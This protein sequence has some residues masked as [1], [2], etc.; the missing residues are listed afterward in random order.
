[1]KTPWTKTGRT[2]VYTDG[3]NTEDG[4]GCAAVA[5]D[6]SVSYILNITASIF[7]AEI[8]AILMAVYQTRRSAAQTVTIATDSRIFIEA[9]RKLYP[10]TL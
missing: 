4:V 10:I 3:S 6:E 9:I 2:I 1:M 7:T 8:G 5:E